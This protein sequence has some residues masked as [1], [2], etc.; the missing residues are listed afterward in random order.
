MAEFSIS[1]VF[2]RGVQVKLFLLFVSFVYREFWFIDAN[3][4]GFISTF[5][6]CMLS[7]YD[8]LASITCSHGYFSISCCSGVITVFDRFSLRLRIDEKDSLYL[9]SLTI[10]SNSVCSI[11][12]VFDL[13]VIGLVDIVGLVDLVCL[14]LLFNLSPL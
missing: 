10:S 9:P 13:C 8:K 11:T 3:P 5:W 1:S 2:C 14:I 7:C 4:F 6:T 12:T